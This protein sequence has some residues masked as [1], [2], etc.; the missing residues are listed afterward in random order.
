[1][2]LVGR[3]KLDLGPLTSAFRDAVA[4]GERLDRPLGD[5]G[6]LLMNS[7]RRNFD[8]GGRPLWKP[9][10]PSTKLAKLGGIGA[11]FGKRGKVKKSAMKRAAS[12]RVNVETGALKK[13]LMFE[14][15]SRYVDVGSS[16]GYARFV[17]E[18]RP[19]LVVQPAD[20]AEAVAILDRWF[21]EP[22]E[23]GRS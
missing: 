1:M 12:L 20:A 15:G 23:G 5:I 2:S 16:L 14:V 11:V 3:V 4:R 17:Q 8:V 7:A 9:L 18:E 21:G 22:L 19:F 10:A 6:K 13:T